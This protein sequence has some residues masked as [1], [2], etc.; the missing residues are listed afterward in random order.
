LPDAALIRPGS[1]EDAPHFIAL[2]ERCWADY[3]DCVLDVDAEAPELR[4]L[5][6]YYAARGGALWIAGEGEGMIATAPEAAGTW[7]ICRVYVHPDRHGTG[8]GAAL[9]RTAERHAIARGAR[10]LFLWSDTRFTRAHRFY[11]KHGYAQGAET[12]ALHDIAAT[13]EA[14][15]AKPAPA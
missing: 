10:L 8:L 9:L 5:A 6:S 2:I 15:F 13:I 7:E 14:R 4:T 1:D 12:R 11:Q 3:P